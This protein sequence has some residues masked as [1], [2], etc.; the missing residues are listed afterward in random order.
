MRMFLLLFLALGVTA[1]G[2]TTKNFSMQEPSYC[3][4][5]SK[6]VLKN[7]D[8]SSSEVVVECSDKQDPMK[9]Y[10]VT[11]G[12]AK[13]CGYFHDEMRLGGKHGWYKQMACYVG[14]GAT[15]RWIIIQNPTN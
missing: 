14:E 2:T 5:S 9:N 15:G 10:M 12:V 7:G 11:S 8:T 4:T 1:C 6:T 3:N 13:E